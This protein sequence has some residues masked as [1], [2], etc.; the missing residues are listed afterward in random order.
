MV[1]VVPSPWPVS[2][3]LLRY[4][5]CC[6]GCVSARALIKTKTKPANKMN[7]LQTQFYCEPH[8]LG[9]PVF[10][11]VTGEFLLCVTTGRIIT[12]WF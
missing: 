5:L 3:E 9:V 8:K 6:M 7:N 4:A 12:S 1:S 11:H 2:C 10:L